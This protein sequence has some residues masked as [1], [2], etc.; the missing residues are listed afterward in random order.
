MKTKP[1]CSILSCL[2]LAA[3]ALPV[4]EVRIPVRELDPASQAV[5]LAVGYHDN[6]R[7]YNAAELAKEA[8]R[9]GVAPASPATSMELA[10]LLLHNRNG[11]DATRATTLLEALLRDNRAEA[12]A[13]QPLARLLLS[14]LSEQRKQ[15]EQ[16][17][18]QL[19]LQ[20]EQQKKLDQLNEK[21]EALKAIERSLTPAPRQGARP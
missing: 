16:L 11:N 8:A 15:E 17:D 13:L 14:Q 20:R 9:L 12:Q 4:K 19:Q 18:K 21:L 7:Q 6:L 2:A 10:L 5:R 1:V 3:C